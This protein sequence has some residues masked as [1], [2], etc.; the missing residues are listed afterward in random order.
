MHDVKDVD[1]ALNDV[2]TEIVSWP[3]FGTCP[4]FQRFYP[5]VQIRPPCPMSR[6]AEQFAMVQYT[7]Q[8]L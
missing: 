6:L 8:L 4:M 2:L 5:K 1:D 3:K 7:I